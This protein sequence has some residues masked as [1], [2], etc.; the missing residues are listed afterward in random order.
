MSMSE[1]EK[2]FWYQKFTLQGRIF[3]PA[4]TKPE[5]TRNGVPKY[6]VLFAWKMDDQ[7]NAPATQAIGAF[8]G[9]V[10]QNYFPSIPMQ[11][12]QNPVK[13]WGEYVRQD[14]KPNHAF[15]EGCYWINLTSGVDFPPPVVDKFKQPVMNEAEIYSG[16]NAV[17]SLSFYRID[18]EKKGAGANI[19]AV[20]LLDGGDQVQ[21]SGSVNI[22]E[23]FGGFAA[24][25]GGAV[26][27]FPAQGNNGQNNGGFGGLL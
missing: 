4:L 23:V 12:F 8:L 19:N 7:R 18:K 14:G 17:V 11:F 24:Q 25:M 22:D 15:L 21:G 5:P 27:S 20:M 2:N 1:Q 13:K 3:Y 16:R 6:S 9:N 10:K 26:A